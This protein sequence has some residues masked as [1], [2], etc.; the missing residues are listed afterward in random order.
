MCA[1]IVRDVSFE[2]TLSEAIEAR[3]LHHQL[4]PDYVQYEGEFMSPVSV[5]ITALP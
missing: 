1:A 2:E 4:L 5:S 3:R